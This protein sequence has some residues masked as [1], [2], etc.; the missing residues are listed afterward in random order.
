MK[1]ITSQVPTQEV[2]ED[3]IAMYDTKVEDTEVESNY[4]EGIVLVLPGDR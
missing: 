4:R 2:D 1:T 3:G